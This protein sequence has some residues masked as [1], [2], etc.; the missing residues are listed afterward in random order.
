MDNLLKPKPQSNDF[1]ENLNELAFILKTSGIRPRQ[2][3]ENMF[4]N[5]SYLERKAALIKIAEA[6]ELGS[7]IVDKQ[8]LDWWMENLFKYISVQVLTDLIKIKALTSLIQCLRLFYR[9]DSTS[10]FSEFEIKFTSKLRGEDWNTVEAQK[11]RQHL[12]FFR[13]LKI[14]LE[15]E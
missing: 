6:I 2:P 15:Q 9:L 8:T 13:E 12:K 7:I 3:F 5:M 1:Q 11:A 4:T 10:G 14:F